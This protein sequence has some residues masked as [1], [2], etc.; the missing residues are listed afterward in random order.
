ME[1]KSRSK[2]LEFALRK[3]EV[4]GGDK[5]RIDTEF[6][7]EELNRRVY[8]AWDG[9]HN[10]REVAVYLHIVGE[11]QIKLQ[12]RL[13]SWELW[14]DN[15]KDP[16]KDFY[17]FGGNGCLCSKE[18]DLGDNLKMEKCHLL[19]NNFWNLAISTEEEVEFLFLPRELS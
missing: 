12:K 8:V 16:K 10:Q 17:R 15:Y 4:D 18:V 7:S 19:E 6:W 11:T 1:R 13:G 3:Q 5:E 9:E 2:V 14:V